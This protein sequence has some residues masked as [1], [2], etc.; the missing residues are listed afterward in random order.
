MPNFP[1]IV[2][3]ILGLWFALALLVAATTGHWFRFLRYM[4]Q[5]EYNNPRKE[6]SNENSQH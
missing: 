4:D 5:E 1:P 2:W 6:E 3:L